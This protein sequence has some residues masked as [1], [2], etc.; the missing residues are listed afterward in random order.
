MCK[1]NAIYS[2][3]YKLEARASEHSGLEGVVSFVVGGAPVRNL[4]V[5]LSLPPSSWMSSFLR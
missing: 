3:V 5:F 1:A 4:L 2:F